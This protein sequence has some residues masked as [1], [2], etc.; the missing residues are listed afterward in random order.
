LVAVGVLSETRYGRTAGGVH[1][2]HQVVGAGPLDILLVG[3]GLSHVEAT[4]EIPVGAQFNTRL[5]LFS[6]L[7]RFDKRGTGLSDPVPLH[8][9]PGLELGEVG[10]GAEPSPSD[11]CWAKP[12]LDAAADAM[13]HL[14][15]HPDV[16]RE[17]GRRARASVTATHD[18]RAPAASYCERF[19][20]LTGAGAVR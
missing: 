6:R 5:A 8:Q 19:A 14:Y 15:D 2:A 12:D 16:A 20:A 1:I 9:I 17:L 3:D 18:A 4:W 11:A 7:I 10:P 13:R